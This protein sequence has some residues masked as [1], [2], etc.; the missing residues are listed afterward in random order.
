MVYFEDAEAEE[1]PIVLKDITWQE[2][3]NNIIEEH[4]KFFKSN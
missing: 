4:S 2:V 1:N 3:K